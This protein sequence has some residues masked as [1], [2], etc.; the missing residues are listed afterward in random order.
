MKHLVF[1]FFFSLIVQ[2]TFGQDS[3]QNS[4]K[5]GKFALQFQLDGSF[6]LKPFQE[7]SFSG[8]YHITD[9]SAIRAGIQISNSVDVESKINDKDTTKQSSFNIKINAQYIY[10]LS[11]VDDI[12]LYTG[13]GLSYGRDL[14]TN[15]G[16]YHD[17]DSWSIGLSGIIGMEWFVKN[18]ISLSGEYSLALNYYDNYYKG[19]DRNQIV[20]RH[21][22]KVAIN[23]YNQFKIGV[24]LYL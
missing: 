18:N 11:I 21:I 3:T 1:I 22:K 5:Q 10:Y 7:T 8:K 9:L 4:L 24:T 12:C 13:S 2:N 23:S 14:Y 6:T 19:P 17:A 16:D 20:E 15:G